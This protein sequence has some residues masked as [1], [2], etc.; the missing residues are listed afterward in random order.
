[1]ITTI[2]TTETSEE[3]VVTVLTEY[4][5]IKLD[6][7]LAR[8]TLLDRQNNCT[9]IKKELSKEE[10]RLVEANEAVRS[11][12]EALR[13]FEHT[14]IANVVDEDLRDIEIARLKKNLPELMKR[15]ENEKPIVLKD[16][17]M[18]EDDEEMEEE[19]G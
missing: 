17:V 4:E 10:D 1:M 11:A 6:L 8:E 18:K 15:L 12:V 16:L 7:K 14:K 19:N 13:T 9:R 3:E 2:T 5:Q